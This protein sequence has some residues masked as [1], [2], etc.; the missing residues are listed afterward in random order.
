MFS[1]QDVDRELKAALSVSPSPDFEARVLRRVEADRPSRWA[2]YGWLAAAASLVM[3]AGVFY[4]LNRTSAVIA[5]PTPAQVVEQT[6]PRGGVVGPVREPPVSQPETQKS[7]TELPRVHA[8]RAQRSA[9]G[10]ASPA[11]PR[12]GEPEVIVPLNQMEAVRRLV[13]AVNEGRIE[14]PAEP[15]PGPMASPET[16]VI[17]P[18]VVAPI[19]IPPVAPAAETPAPTIRSLK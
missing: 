7:T 3:V 4:A 6:T 16:L 19:S 5:P 11:R 12:T 8:T 13:H 14:V 18:I 2:H 1:E 17:V 15:Q 9:P 10:S